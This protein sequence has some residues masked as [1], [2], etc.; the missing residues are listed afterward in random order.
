MNYSLESLFNIVFRANFKIVVCKLITSLSQEW[1]LHWMEVIQFSIRIVPLQLSLFLKAVNG[2]PL[3]TREI[4]VDRAFL[5]H[6]PVVFF[7]D[8]L[9][10]F[11]LVL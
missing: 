8:A 10:G 9:S 5:H 11:V 7:V 4:T 6:R 1:I 2:R 3:A